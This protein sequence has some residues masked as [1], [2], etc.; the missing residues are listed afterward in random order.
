MEE[1]QFFAHSIEDKTL[2]EQREL[3]IRRFHEIIKSKFITT[4][5]VNTIFFAKYLIFFKEISNL[6]CILVYL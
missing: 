2:D 4:D 5:D 3:S 1:N 6:F